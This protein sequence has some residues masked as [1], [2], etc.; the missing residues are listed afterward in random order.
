M[1]IV[2]SKLEAE[3]SAFQLLVSPHYLIAGQ[4]LTKWIFDELE[5]NLHPNLGEG[6]NTV[7]VKVM[8][9]IIGVCTEVSFL[10]YTLAI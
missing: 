3:K 7:I 2:V 6:H 8:S 5:V 9:F 10:L 1:K 4:T